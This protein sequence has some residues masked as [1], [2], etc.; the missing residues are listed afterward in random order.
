[1]IQIDRK[2]YIVR[3]YG[4]EPE[5][6]ETIIRREQPFKGP[7]KTFIFQIYNNPQLICDSNKTVYPTP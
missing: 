1:M 4:T 6:T 5:S 3:E 2:N 7:R